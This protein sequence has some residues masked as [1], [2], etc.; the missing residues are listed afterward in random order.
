MRKEH[1][2]HC[3]PATTAQH[4]QVVFLPVLW[5]VLCKVGEIFC[6]FVCCCGVGISTTVSLSWCR[7]SRVLCAVLSTVGEYL[8]L[9][10]GAAGF[11]L[12]SGQQCV[13]AMG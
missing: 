6:V 10:C 8:V 12:I 1:R 2:R 11:V 9:C 7:Y 13:C 3:A 4:A 5:A